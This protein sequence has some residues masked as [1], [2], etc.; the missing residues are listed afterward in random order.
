MPTGTRTRRFRDGARSLSVAFRAS[1][2]TVSA[3]TAI[4]LTYRLTVRPR[5]CL[6]VLRVC[7]PLTAALA[8]GCDGIFRTAALRRHRLRQR[9]GRSSAHVRTAPSGAVVPGTRLFAA[10]TRPQAQLPAGSPHR[11]V[12]GL[13]SV[14]GAIHASAA[15]MLGGVRVAVERA[16]ARVRAGYALS[17]RSRTRFAMKA[18]TLTQSVYCQCGA[19][20]TAQPPESRTLDAAR[21]ISIVHWSE[22]RV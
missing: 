17:D 7:V 19:R 21:S 13:R 6:P 11:C 5:W 22:P 9:D 10:R 20:P 12:R 14:C 8:G 1:G 15:W 2:G 4:D 18:L 16:A 3:A